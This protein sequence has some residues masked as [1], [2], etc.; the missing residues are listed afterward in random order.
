MIVRVSSTNQ[1]R[2]LSTDA[3]GFHFLYD[4]CFYLLQRAAIHPLGVG[5]ARIKMV[6]DIYSVAHDPDLVR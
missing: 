2:S 6:C 4:N 5:K 3:G 1:G